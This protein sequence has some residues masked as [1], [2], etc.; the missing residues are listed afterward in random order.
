MDVVQWRNSSS[1]NIGLDGSGG[2]MDKGRGGKRERAFDQVDLIAFTKVGTL[3]GV[4][5]CITVTVVDDDVLNKVF[6][7]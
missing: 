4:G 7:D 6:W 2:W 3:D 5:G 1:V